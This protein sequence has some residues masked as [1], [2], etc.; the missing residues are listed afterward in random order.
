VQACCVCWWR[1]RQHRVRSVATRRRVRA[2]TFFLQK[3][4]R[5][6]LY[7][8]VD[9]FPLIPLLVGD[10]VGVFVAEVVAEL[11]ALLAAD[12][13]I[14]VVGELVGWLV[15]EVAHLFP[16]HPTRSSQT[17]HIIAATVEA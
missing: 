2:L 4:I 1:V 16:T 12:V 3:V 6:V 17:K 10:V 8:P 7:F 11:V 14:G 13:L 15:A 5:N 9:T